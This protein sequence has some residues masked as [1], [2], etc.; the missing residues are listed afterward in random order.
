MLFSGALTTYRTLII[1]LFLDD[2][3]ISHTSEKCHVELL[4]TRKRVKV[5]EAKSNLL[6]LYVYFLYTYQLSRRKSGR[7]K[8]GRLNSIIIFRH[9]AR[10]E[11]GKYEY[12]VQ[13]I[14]LGVNNFMI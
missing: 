3:T 14:D 1:V 8:N 6:V 7:R 13:Q 12:I 5:H 4:A 11:C 9:I 2:Y 10:G